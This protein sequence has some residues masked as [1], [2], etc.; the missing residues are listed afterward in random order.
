LDRYEGFGFYVPAC[1]AGETVIWEKSRFTE[2][3]TV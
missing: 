2:A 1:R 3:K